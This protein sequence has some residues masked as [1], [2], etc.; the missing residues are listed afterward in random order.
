MVEVARPAFDKPPNETGYIADL[1]T[2]GP[3][4]PLICSAPCDRVLQTSVSALRAWKRPC[5]QL[6]QAANCQRRA[7]VV[8]LARLGQRSGGRT[9][10]DKMPWALW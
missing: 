2:S 5:L 7:D 1:T 3:K 4:R 9:C 8:L 10:W 6:C